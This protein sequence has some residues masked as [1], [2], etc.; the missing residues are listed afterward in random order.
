MNRKITQTSAYDQ[1]LQTALKHYAEAEWLGEHSPLAQ[2]YFL[3]AHAG[4]MPSAAQRGRALQAAIA[5][6]WEALWDGALPADEKTLLDQFRDSM[7]KRGKD[8]KYFA[9]A[10][11]LRYLRRVIRPAKLCMVWDDYLYT[12]KAQYHR[13][14]PEAVRLLGENLLRNVHPRLHLEQPNPPAALYG[15]QANIDELFGILCSGKSINLCG[16]SGVGKSSLSAAVCQRWPGG[17]FFWYTLRPCLNDRL[18]NFL[19]ALA[20]FLHQ[21][22]A[23]DL[24]QQIL[25][26]Q[27]QVRNSEMAESLAMCAIQQLDPLPL[28][29][30]DDADLLRPVTFEAQ[31][32]EYARFFGFLERLGEN[33]TALFVGQRATLP[34]TQPIELGGIDLAALRQWLR[35]LGMDDQ[36]DDLQDLLNYTSGAPRL[37]TLCLALIQNGTPAQEITAQLKSRPGVG[38]LMSRLVNQ[39]GAV[40]RQTLAELAVFRQS[41]PA[42][43]WQERRPALKNL[44]ERGLVQF[45]LAGG[46]S[47][48]SVWADLVLAEL[49]PETKAALHGWAARVR[50]ERGEYTES[51]YHYWQA[52]YPEAAIQIWYPN[53]EHALACGEAANAGAIFNTVAAH[54]LPQ[55]EQRALALIR[56]DLA[57]L[58]GDFE[59]GLRD[60]KDVS[61][62]ASRASSEAHKLRGVLL[63]A[64]G[65]NFGALR[66]YQAGLDDLAV[67]TRQQVDLLTGRSARFKDEGEFSQA[68]RELK[69]ARYLVEAFQGNLFDRQGQYAQARQSYLLALELAGEL[70]DKTY[71]AQTY[72]NIG[73]MIALREPEEAFSYLRLALET[74]EKKGDRVEAQLV[75]NNLVVALM[76]AGR[77]REA[78]P[79]AQSVVD[80]ALGVCQ[81]P[82]AADA[83][84]N[85]SEI[86]FNLGNFDEALHWAEVS[87]AQEQT[88]VI[89]YALYM[90]GLV[91]NARKNF[92]HAETCFRG[93]IQAETSEPYIIACAWRGLGET[94]QL[95]GEPARACQAF[96]KAIELFEQQNMQAEVNKTRTL[97]V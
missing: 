9:L 45:D 51:A 24:W 86:F 77:Y 35:A 20:F 36:P 39:V 79:L 25:A 57:R 11:E 78:L 56:A 13:D 70:D 61:W 95:N 26:D 6:A 49:A 43:A 37:L 59:K 12:S 42:D 15:R 48:L 75:Q 81:R 60:L 19:F 66:E 58:N 17:S 92:A 76:Q 89:P 84:V 21:R 82:N 55:A 74:F 14:L 10:L 65:D 90:I 96:Y 88:A 80:F 72:T 22:G 27:G 91:D 29:V 47:L 28:L 53:R 64:L 97:F 67:L 32:P 71:L 16:M 7:Q 87:M 33:A 8:G 18:D 69:R 31:N 34:D 94:Y 2:P 44:S 3:G 30:I 23:S 83:A 68:S 63:M 5:E 85:L 62:P 38:A 1:C 52:G 73:A 54:R 4:A 50:S 40:E 41:A 93:I 46:V